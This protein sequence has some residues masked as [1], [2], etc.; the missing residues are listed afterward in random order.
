VSRPVRYGLAVSEEE[1]GADAPVL[2]QGGLENAFRRAAAWGFETV[3]IHIRNP[4]TLDAG[5]VADAAVDAG[6]GISA[7]GTGLE[8]SLNNLNL[9]SPDVDVRRKT[10]VR[11]REHIDLASRFDAT[12]FVGLC[13]GTAPD[14]VQRDEYLD[15]FAGELVP[16]AEYAQRREVVLSLEPIA[17][18]MT[19]L[20]NTT[21]ETLAFLS[22][23]G[24]E[25]IMLLMDTHHM[26]IEDG[27]MDQTFDRCKD[28]IA[29]LH[30]SDSDRRFG[31]SGEIDYAAVGA[32][33][34]RIGYDRSVS[35]EILPDPDGE[36]AALKGLSWMREVWGE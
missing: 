31:V 11:F 36:T 27:D 14:S 6:V 12:V 4:L 10:S 22:R 16:L 1:L 7:V 19:S 29:H 26:F 30:I 8:Y 15:R 18:Y 32:S 5:A 17:A 13:R 24:L 33:L 9:T 34:K 2:I 28:R 21:Q 20:L 35:L 23:P 25:T 3:E